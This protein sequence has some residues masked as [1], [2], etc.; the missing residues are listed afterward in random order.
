MSSGNWTRYMRKDI[1]E[2]GES[3]SVGSSRMSSI[4]TILH[5]ASL[6]QS[7]SIHN[8]LSLR[9]SRDN[10]F[11]QNFGPALG[12]NVSSVEHLSRHGLME[13]KRDDKMASYDDA[14]EIMGIS[15]STNKSSIGGADTEK[16]PSN[17]RSD[18]NISENEKQPAITIPVRQSQVSRKNARPKAYAE[19]IHENDVLCGRGGKSNHHPGNKRYRQVI[20]ELKGN[21]RD[22]S[23]KTEKTRVSRE[24]VSTVYEYGGRF[25]KKEDNSGKYYIMPENEARRKTSQ[26]LRE[27]KEL[28]WLD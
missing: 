6:E 7:G 11:G 20:C 8:L 3:S 16:Q 24:I 1:F 5:A 13:E 10:S 22:L 26:A 4:D 12:Q 14:M 18:R 23:A 21:Y 17:M 9:Q 28:K 25:L 15:R 19:N 2:N 27:T